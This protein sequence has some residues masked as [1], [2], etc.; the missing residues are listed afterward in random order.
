MRNRTEKILWAVALVIAGAAAWPLLA[1]AGLLNTRGGGDSPFLLQRVQQLVT[2]VSDGHFP[3]RWMPDANFGYGY[4]F[5]NYYAPLAFYVAGAFYALGASLIRAVQLSQLAAFLVA[6]G[7]MFALGRRWFASPWVALLVSAAYTLAPFH[8]VNV[9]VRGDSIAEFWAMAFY[10]LIFL[11][12]EHTAVSAPRARTWAEL[13]WCGVPLALAYAGLALSHNISAL[14]FSP[15]VLAYALVRWWGEVHKQNETVPQTASRWLRAGLALLPFVVAGLLGLALSAWFWLPALGEQNLTQVG[16][17]TADY[18]RYDNHF[19]TAVTLIQPSW[20]FDFGVDDLQA[21]RLG[22][23]QTLFIG[24]GFVAALAHLFFRPLTPVAKNTTRFLLVALLTAVF[25]MTPL[26]RPLWDN[27]PLLPFVQFPWRFLGLVAFWGAAVAGYGLALATH[28]FHNFQ[29]KQGRTGGWLVGLLTAVGIAVLAFTSLGQLQPDYLYLTDADVT[30]ERLALYEWFTGNIGTTISAEYLPPTADP[31]AYT[32]HWLQ[33]GDRW[34]AWVVAGTAVVQQPPLIARTGHQVWAI[35]VTSPTAE[36]VLPLLYWP[37]W[38]ARLGDGQAVE[39]TAV[40]GS[41]LARVAL[42]QGSHHLTLDLG[43]TAVRRTAETISL[44]ALFLVCVLWLLR[45]APRPNPQPKPVDALDTTP[46]TWARP[47]LWAFIAFLLTMVVFVG[48]IAR[49]PLPNNTLNMDFAQL[50]YLHHQ[51]QGI[52]YGNGAHLA[53]Y[54]L[55]TDTAVAGETITLT[56]DWSAVPPGDERHV[57]VALTTAATHFY[58]FVP[59]LTAVSQPL[60][61]GQVTYRLPIPANAPPGLYVPQLTLS[62]NNRPRTLSGVPRGPLTLAPLR[63][64][65][66]DSAADTAVSPSGAL[67]VR[68]VQVAQRT[69]EPRALDVQLA[70]YTAVDIPQHLKLSL[71]LTN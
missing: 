34:Q 56:L 14:I 2:A 55:S 30:A 19:R 51:P 3:V 17:T 65:A 26:S 43:R 7:G 4:P 53:G 60:T 33:S 20:L 45:P 46:A 5:Y 68:A 49:Q 61:A 70:W 25:M 32:S 71:R 64:V 47:L 63:V 50:G 58:N 10:P 1:E 67:D 21:F 57:T 59:P 13:F 54:A 37:G 22:L 28:L 29:A 48:Q 24:L 15:F 69:G 41:G 16:N 31:R 39:L 9:Y 23:V 12:I 62:D 38:Q 35:E 40:A 52:A 27:L 66:A 8:L 6:G 18:F 36:V 44:V 42:P 11:A